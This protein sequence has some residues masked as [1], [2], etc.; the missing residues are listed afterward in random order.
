MPP[1]MIEKAAVKIAR[2]MEQGATCPTSVTAGAVP[3]S[4]S[5]EGLGERIATPAEQARNDSEEKVALLPVT[6]AEL[7]YLISDTISYIWK[8]EGRGIAKPEYGYDSRKAL[9]EKLKKFEKLYFPELDTC[10]G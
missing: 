2:D 6:K 7:S 10:S 8:L 3:P 1:G 9:L 5:G 4:P